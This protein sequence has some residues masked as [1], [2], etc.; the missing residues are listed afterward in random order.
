MA[1]IA[2]VL[3][4]HL[5][6]LIWGRP[7]HFLI[8][9]EAICLFGLLE[10]YN[11]C[12]AGGKKPHRLA[13]VVTGAVFLAASAYRPWL[14]GAAAAALVVAVLAVPV[15]R[16]KP[17]GAL[18]DAGASLFAFAYVPGLLAFLMLLRQ[19]PAGVRLL[20]LLFFTIWA[21]DIA[22]YFAGRAFGR[23]RLAPAISPGKTVEGAVAGFAAG[24]VTA[25]VCA[26][27]V[28]PETGLGW[29]GGLA[30]G[31]ALT[32]GGLV[33]D[34]AESALKRDAGVKDAGSLLPGHGGVLDRL[35]AVM[36]G[37]PLFYAVVRVAARLG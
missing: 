20:L 22:A 7:Y 27:F 37:A 2:V 13:V 3:P 6:I 11:L 34:L 31:V 17:A 15:G 23:R 10:M 9:L 5:I 18:G 30:A 24:I 28:F 35:D 14:A 8:Y 21:A 25:V 4:V 1:T 29:L 16:G 36:F 19:Q 26:R 32:G 12:E 33:G